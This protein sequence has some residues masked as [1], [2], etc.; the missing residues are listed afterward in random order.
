MR[1]SA[2]EFDDGDGFLRWLEE[3]EDFGPLPNNDK[4]PLSDSDDK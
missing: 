4:A 3:L 2:A 1:I